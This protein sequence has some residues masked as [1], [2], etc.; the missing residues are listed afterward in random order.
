VRRPRI[1]STID[2]YW[3]ASAE[4]ARPGS[5]GPDEIER[6]DRGNEDHGFDI[7]DEVAAVEEQEQ[8]HQAQGAP[9]ARLAA[10]ADEG[11]DDDEEDRDRVRE[12]VEAVVQR[13][14]ER[15]GEG[16]KGE[17]ALARP[18]RPDRVQQRQRERDDVARDQ[19]LLR[20]DRVQ[21]E[22]QQGEADLRG[23]VGCGEQD[24]L[25]VV[26]VDATRA[27][28]QVPDQRRSTHVD[29]A[30]NRDETPQGE[31]DEELDGDRPDEEGPERIEACDPA[32]HGRTVAMA[33][34]AGAFVPRGSGTI[35]P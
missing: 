35:A 23:E 9:P 34:P 14:G 8:G 3:P 19:H 26:E 18:E 31:D 13:E 6:A 11:A 33:M 10:E 4:R 16:G 1:G 29:R 22:H 2:R 21:D 15:E 12:V 32:G 5:N 24:D 27:G 7:G 17:P 20:G 25:D 30:V 28:Q